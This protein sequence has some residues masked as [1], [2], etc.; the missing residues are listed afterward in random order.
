MTVFLDDGTSYETEVNA[1]QSDEDIQQYFVGQSFNYGDTE[2][3]PKDLV[4]KCVKVRNGE[5]LS[6]PK[7]LRQR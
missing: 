5:S 6:D 2:S 4:K 7:P 3:H 1:S